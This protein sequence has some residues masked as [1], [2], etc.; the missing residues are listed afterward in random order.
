MGIFEKQGF[1]GEKSGSKNTLHIYMRIYIYLGIRISLKFQSR[2]GFLEKPQPR[3]NFPASER[4]RLIFLYQ[5][6]WLKSPPME[7]CVHE[8]Q[9]VLRCDPPTSSIFAEVMFE[10]ELQLL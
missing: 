1:F 6:R 8:L 7:S 3:R 10:C 9:A 4:S 2:R 5:P